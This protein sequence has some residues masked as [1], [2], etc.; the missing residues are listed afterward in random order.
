M[1]VK[2]TNP[3]KNFMVFNAVLFFAVLF[4]TALFL[5]LAYTF[6]RDAD[7]VVSYKGRYHI[8][9]S[10][11]FAGEGL[12]IYVNDSLLLDGTMPDTL[13]SLDVNRFA[14]E[15]ALLIVD[16]QTDIVTPFNLSKEGGKVI[17]K[18][19]GSKIMMEETPSRF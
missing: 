11:D 9:V 19:E 8:E 17:I 15:H 10:T 5:Y 16:K 1:A 18:K 13:V 14:E 3:H 7:K 4:I 12:S 2:R 6:K